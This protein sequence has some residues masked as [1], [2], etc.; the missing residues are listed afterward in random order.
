MP[1]ENIF[2]ERQRGDF[3]RMHSINNYI[4]ESRLNEEEFY[5]YCDEYDSI[6][7]GLK[8]RNMDGFAEGRSIVSYIMDI[9]VNKFIILIPYNSY[10][11]SRKHLDMEFYNKI[12]NKVN[13]FFEFNKNHIWINKKV[14]D[15]MYKIDSIGGA[16]EINVKRMGKNGYFLVIDEFLIYEH[17]EYFINLIKTNNDNQKENDFVENYEIIF[18]NLYYCL[19]HIDTNIENKTKEFLNNSKFISNLS[20]LDNLKKNLHIYIQTKRENKNSDKCKM[21]ILNLIKYQRF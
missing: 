19:K 16:N 1:E 21:I 13:S 15:K 5:K 18:Y 8:S 11:N 14:N 12:Y 4:G 10:A 2:C 20:F 17:V 9:L 7:T 3:C 6:I